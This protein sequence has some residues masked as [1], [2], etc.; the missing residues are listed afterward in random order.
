MEKNL[1]DYSNNYGSKATL[2]IQYIDWS[3]EGEGGFFK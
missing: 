3:W 1:I 2:I